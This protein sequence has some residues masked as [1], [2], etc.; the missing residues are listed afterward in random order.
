MP[1][2]STHESTL[3]HSQVRFSPRVAIKKESVCFAM[4]CCLRCSPLP[5]A[6]R[7][8]WPGV[9]CA[10]SCQ[11]LPRFPDVWQGAER[12]ELSFA[13]S[14]FR[15]SRSRRAME[16]LPRLPLRRSRSRRR[17]NVE[18]TEI[19]GRSGSSLRCHNGRIGYDPYLEGRSCSSQPHG[20]LHSSVTTG[21]S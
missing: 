19:E 11:R 3:Y 2:E 12:R 6:F 13:G 21:A 9:G 1:F 5:V 16:R 10:P 20:A 7:R 17:Y 18:F 4:G 15:S 8:C 14:P